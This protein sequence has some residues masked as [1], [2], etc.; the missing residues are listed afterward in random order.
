MRKRLIL[1]LLC[2]LTFHFVIEA[3]K[4][5]EFLKKLSSEKGFSGA[6]LI[7]KNKKILLNQ[8]YGF[9]D[10]QKTKQFK[11]D[12]KFYIASITK[13]FTAVAILKLQEQGKLSVNDSIT[14][15]FKDVPT[16]KSAIDALPR[17]S[18]NGK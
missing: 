2:V 14:T 10:L 5:R 9:A 7:A 13:Q 4:T 11:N 6:V 3:Q 1:I 8:G 17:L 18:V 15:F 12:T 16:D